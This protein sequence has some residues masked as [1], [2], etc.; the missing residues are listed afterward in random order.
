VP[1]V[2][3]RKILTFEEIRAGLS[4]M[5]E[6]GEGAQRTQAY[7]MLMSMGQ[8]DAL[9]PAPL[10]RDDVTERMARVIR[11]VGVLI[12]RAAFLKAQPRHVGAYKAVVQVEK[13]TT[14][15]IGIPKQ[16]WPITVRQLYK[17]CPELKRR[18]MPKGYPTKGGPLKQREFLHN[19][20]YRYHV[21]KQGAI[22]VALLGELQGETARDGDGSGNTL[23]QTGR[24]PEG[25]GGEG[26][27]EGSET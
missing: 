16:D 20:F 23:E 19:L 1:E 5:A 6:N 7:R 14:I 13:L 4:E 25:P 24:Q 15:D 2:T 8:Q 11:G 3:P 10:H 22:N 18:G 21:D 26:E 27:A 12:T 17:H 9:L